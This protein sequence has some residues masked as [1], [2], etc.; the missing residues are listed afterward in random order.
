MLHAHN[1]I[2][3]KNNLIDDIITKLEPFFGKVKFYIF[4]KYIIIIFILKSTKISIAKVLIYHAN[5][6]QDSM[7][8]SQQMIIN[9][10]RKSKENSPMLLN[11]FS[12]TYD[13]C[14]V[15]ILECANVST[16]LYQ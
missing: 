14:Q 15:G 9:Q 8:S 7:L 11:Y 5:S 12:S 6:P 3:N 16:I 4:S 13:E 10:I 1:I 2:E